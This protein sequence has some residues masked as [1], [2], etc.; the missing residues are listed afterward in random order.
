MIGKSKIFIFKYLDNLWGPHS[1]DRF[2][3]D[4]NAKCKQFFSKFW[5]PGTGGIDA[6]RFTW[7][8][9]NN[10]LVPPPR[11][12]PQV[13]NKLEHEKCK[14]TLID[15]EWTSAPFWPMVVNKDGHFKK[16]IVAHKSFQGDRLVKRGR[17]QN[18]IF[19]S[20]QLNFRLVALRIQF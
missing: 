17:G 7:A 3:H 18:G 12:I 8:C 1:S 9:T 4:Y 15:P 14:G 20:Q 5:C 6:F 16:F 19:G 10:W 13:I 2:A 11:L